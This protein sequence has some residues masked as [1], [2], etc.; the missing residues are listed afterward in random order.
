VLPKPGVDSLYV[1]DEKSDGGGSK[2]DIDTRISDS[3]DLP[4]DEI[5]SERVGLVDPGTELSTKEAG[6]LDP[7]YICGLRPNEGGGR[8]DG[9]EICWWTWGVAISLYWLGER[10]RVLDW[11]EAGRGILEGGDN[12]LW[13]VVGEGDREYEELTLRFGAKVD[14]V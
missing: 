13:V 10:V 14:E 4:I 12:E 9:D 5:D 8:V 6:Q 11:A 1:A 7:G 2:L 3:E